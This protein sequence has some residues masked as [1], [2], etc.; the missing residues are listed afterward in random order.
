MQPP[1]RNRRDLTLSRLPYF[2]F[3]SIV[4][5]CTEAY[6]MANLAFVIGV[7]SDSK[8]MDVR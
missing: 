2:F 8:E 1:P 7:V 5:R 6:G 3:L 4:G